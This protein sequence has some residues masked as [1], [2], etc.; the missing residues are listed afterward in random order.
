V[1]GEEKGVDVRV[2]DDEEEQSYA[3]LPIEYLLDI[4]RL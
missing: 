4:I 3:I 2:G 1:G